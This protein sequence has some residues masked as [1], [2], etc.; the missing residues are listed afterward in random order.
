MGGQFG[1][2]T[3]Q[4]QIQQGR[5][6]AYATGVSA[7]LHVAV[8]EVAINGRVAL[9]TMAELDALGRVVLASGPAGEAKPGRKRF[10]DHGRHDPAPAVP[11]DH[12]VVCPREQPPFADRVDQMGKPGLVGQRLAEGGAVGQQKTQA[13]P[14]AGL[15][16]HAEFE[17]EQGVVQACNALG[18]QLLVIDGFDGALWRYE[19][20]RVEP[21]VFQQLAAVEPLVLQMIKQGANQRCGDRGLH[22]MS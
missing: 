1:I 17:A 10:F 16:G 12:H 13:A 22:A 2:A 19:R 5:V 21:D 9:G 11:F 4:R 18:K 8:E 6:E 7:E 15:G 14:A 20:G 3:S